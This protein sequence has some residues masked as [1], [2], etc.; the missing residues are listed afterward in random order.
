VVVWD[1]FVPPPRRAGGRLRARLGAYPDDRLIVVRDEC[2]GAVDVARALG[3]LGSGHVLVLLGWSRP[4]G[5]VL[6][7]ARSV[8]AADRVRRG[9]PAP[10]DEML[11]MTA[12]ADV[13][14]IPVPPLDRFARLSAPRTLF[15]LVAAAVPIVAPN[16]DELGALVRSTGAGV[17][18][19][20]RSPADPGAI[21]EG[22]RTILDDPSLG[23]A[24][25]HGARRALVEDLSWDAQVERLT[26]VYA[27][28]GARV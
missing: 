6:Q 12:G 16:L 10:E 17:L 24:C 20:G 14:V 26:A 27:A 3:I 13:A 25:R 28:L 23:A 19:P 5:D 18:Y 9:P 2:D 11:E 7:A 4:H 8:G 21:A 22:I 15:E 1:A